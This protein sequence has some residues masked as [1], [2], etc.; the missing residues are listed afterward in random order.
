M[1]YSEQTWAVSKCRENGRS[2]PV[3]LRDIRRYMTL[4][5]L[6]YSGCFLLHTL[7]KSSLWNQSLYRLGR[8]F[9]RNS[10]GILSGIHSGFGSLL[11]RIMIWR[12]KSEASRRCPPLSTYHLC[13]G[14]P[15]LT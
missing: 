7:Q 4:L 10:S 11:A 6:L 15:R 12:R 1:N 14:L 2:T 9:W 13:S 8:E 3:L 5:R